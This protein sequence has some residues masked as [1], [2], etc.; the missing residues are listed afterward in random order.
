MILLYRFALRVLLPRSARRHSAA[1][2]E[3]ARSLSRDAKHAGRVAHTRYWAQ[4]FH[5]LCTVTWTETPQRKALPMFSTL[6][7]DIRYGVRLLVRTPGITAIAL[8]TLALGIGANTAIFS[9]IDGVLLRPLAY[10]DPDRLLLVRQRDASDPDSLS[11]TSPGMFYDVQQSTR[12]FDT[13]AAYQVVSTTLTGKGDPERIEGVHSVG[14][15]LSV[16]GVR[17]QIGRM[18]SEE[19]DR[20]GAP[21]NVVISHRLWQRLFNGR[22]D[23]LGQNLTLDGEPHTVVGIMPP[24]FAFPDA[25]REFWAP[26]QMTAKMRASRTENFLLIVARLRDGV[27]ADAARGELESV[28]ARLR[29]E[30]PVANNNVLLDAQPLRDSVVADVSR[31]L[32]ILMAGVGCVLLIACANLANLLLARATRRRHELAVRQA[33]GASRSRIVRQLLVESLV[34]AFVGGL[35]GAAVGPLFLDAVVAWLPADIPRLSSATIDLRVLLFTIAVS[36]LTGVVVGL[37]PAIQATRREGT[38]LVRVDTRTSTSRSVLRSMLVV[39]EVAVAVLLLAGAGLLIRSFVLLQRV[40]AGF[41]AENVLTFNLRFEGREYEEPA[42]RVAAVN[43]IVERLQ[44]LP[45]AVGAS[46]S[47]YVPLAG[48]GTAA[49]FNIVSRPVPPGGTPESIPY[50]VIT[51]DY[52][53]VMQI[54]LLRGRLLTDADGIGG[55][56]SVVISESAARRFWPTAAQGDPIGS[57]V[58]LGPPENKFARATIVG[59]VKDVK[60]TELGSDVTDALYGLN[61]LMPFWRGFTFAIRTSGDPLSVA[62][63]ARRMVRERAPT[64]AITALRPMTEIVHRSQGPARASMSLLVLFAVIAG[65]MAAIGVFGVMSYVVNLRARELGIRLALGATGSELQRMVMVDGM[66]Q[67]LTGVVLGL[68]AAAWLTRSMRALLYGVAPGDPLTLFVVGSL[69]IASAALACFVPAR[70]ATRIDPLTVL[71]AE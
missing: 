47:S 34:L 67:A 48:W 56:P 13:M 20:I 35:A 18:L 37:A 39:T 22:S 4:E 9:I 52:F 65:V 41:S 44:V 59:I 71:R 61:S 16:L 11:R 26:M 1:M 54:R 2:L 42:A 36:S 5:A 66:A 58:Y 63:D 33:I 23:A 64:V 21:R 12:S 32:W 31:Q 15:V 38:V 68:V 14:S 19:D 43:A 29:A 40:D 69:L 49:W 27:S 62:A 45:G 25:E 55:T 10:E 57:E 46:A 6:L 30:F 53:K 28:M 60:L 7:Q 8:I 3:T 17:P 24:W 70:R 50:R 51:P